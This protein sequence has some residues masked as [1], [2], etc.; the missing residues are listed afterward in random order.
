MMKVP[1]RMK[2]KV[3]IQSLFW[4]EELVEIGLACPSGEMAHQDPSYFSRYC[5]TYMWWLC[6]LFHKP[7]AFPE[8]Y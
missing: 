4:E 5:K 8:S 6:R 7:E 1:V 2:S 3:Q